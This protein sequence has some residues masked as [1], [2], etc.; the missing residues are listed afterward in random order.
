MTQE[1]KSHDMLLDIATKHSE[2]DTVFPLESGPVNQRNEIR[3]CTPQVILVVVRNENHAVKVTASLY[4]WRCLHLEAKQTVQV[5]NRG[6]GVRVQ[7]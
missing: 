3:L 6:N 7:P 4:Q 1:K 2:S 5:L